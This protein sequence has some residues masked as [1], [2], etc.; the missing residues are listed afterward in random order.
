[1][2]KALLVEPFRFTPET[3][4]CGRR[5]RFKGAVALDRLV[6]GVIELRNA[7]QGYVPSGIRDLWDAED[8]DRQGCVTVRLE[9]GPGPLEERLRHRPVR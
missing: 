7:Q 1:M 4:K 2:L 6:E 3:N 9:L 5:Y 8:P